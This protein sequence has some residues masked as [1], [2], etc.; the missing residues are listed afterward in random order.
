MITLCVGFY[1]CSSS[2]DDD[3]T[4]TMAD[5]FNKYYN[6]DNS[7]I[8]VKSVTQHGD[9]I[10]LS[11]IRN[12]HLWYRLLSEKSKNTLLEWED[13]ENTTDTIIPRGYGEKKYLVSLGPAKYKKTTLGS[14]VT[15]GF[16]YSLMKD[17][18]CID[19]GPDY[20]KTIF[21]NNGKTKRTPLTASYPHDNNK[22]VPDLILH[23][24]YKESVFINNC[25]YSS[26]GDTLYTCVAPSWDNIKLVASYNEAICA[27]ITNYSLS[28]FSKH[29]FKE[30][31]DTWSVTIRPP[32]DIPSGADPRYTYTLLDNT[33]NI[34]KYKVNMVYYDGT[35]KEFTFTIN[36]DTGEYKAANS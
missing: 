36:F 29:N 3:K 27:N 23:D 21:T 31:K 25:C 30:N 19:D 26:E 13:T 7:T 4:V 10:W 15:F 33:T 9:S 12:N 11:G 34:W 6:G 22:W 20:Y 17:A 2:K 24:W 14:I 18:F 16:R 32:F 8:I 28:N 5:L 35:K 1:S